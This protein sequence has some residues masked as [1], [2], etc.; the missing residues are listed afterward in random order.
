MRT[1]ETLGKLAPALTKALAEMKNPP[2]SQTV[3]A[4]NYSYTFAPMPEIVDSAR[5]ILAKY[6]LALFQSTETHDG[7]PAIV[8]MILHESGEWVASD[9]LVMAPTKNDPQSAGGAIT[10][11]RR[12]SLSAMLG[13]AADDDDDA[14]HASRDAAPRSNALPPPDGGNDQ[15]V[16]EKQAKFLHVLC[17]KKCANPEATKQA[18]YT[19]FNVTDFADL[20]FSHGKKLIDEMA[21]R[22]DYDPMASIPQDVLTEDELGAVPF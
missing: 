7:F 4:G 21:G 8:T 5:P 19:K 18:I 6:G 2:K 16:S 20:H 1:S 11:A 15:R 12:Y 14:Q 17:K 9:P 3:K 22:P 10:Y 13:L